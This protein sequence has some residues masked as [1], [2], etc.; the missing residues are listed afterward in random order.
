LETLTIQLRK[1]L[2]MKEIKKKMTIL[3]RPSLKLKRIMVN[4]LRPRIK[5]NAIRRITKSEVPLLTESD[6]N[7][8]LYFT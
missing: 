6:S 3:L 5:R 7:L 4:K 1:L 2:R 8:L